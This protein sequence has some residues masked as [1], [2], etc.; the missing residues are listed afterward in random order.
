MHVLLT[1][2]V[3]NNF[4][5]NIKDEMRN[6]KQISEKHKIRFYDLSFSKDYKL[7]LRIKRFLIKSAV[8]VIK[9]FPVQL[10]RKI[11]K[12]LL[13]MSHTNR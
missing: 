13:S 2:R 12:G 1:K 10:V 5:N 4:T 3:F 8:F 9:L 6:I 11:A 7:N